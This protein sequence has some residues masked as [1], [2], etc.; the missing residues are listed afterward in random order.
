MGSDI[1]GRLRRAE[2]KVIPDKFSKDGRE[3][4][5]KLKELSRV[6]CE[7]KDYELLF[8]LP[9]DEKELEGLKNILELMEL[10]HKEI[11]FGTDVKEIH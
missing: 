6:W 2:R 11:D 4:V 3:V 5:N 7:Y 8:D 1:K 9:R 10:G